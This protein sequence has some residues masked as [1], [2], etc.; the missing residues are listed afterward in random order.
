MTP[1]GRRP[2]ARG[3]AI[4]DS[5]VSR[6]HAEISRDSEGLFSVRD[7]GS[8]NGTSVDGVSIVTSKPLTKNCRL[9]FGGVEL[10]FCIDASDLV[11]DGIVASTATIQAEPASDLE[12][13]ETSDPE[14][15]TFAG[16]PKIPISFLQPSAGGAGLVDIGDCRIQLTP[17]QFDLM[18]LLVNQMRSE[19][20]QVIELRGYLPSAQLI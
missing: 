14:E 15:A 2:V 20:E 3:I 16:F 10:Y 19:S 9:L 6:N 5:S 13:D 8:S 1:V 12:I 18:T 7:V 17:A 11:S 4:L